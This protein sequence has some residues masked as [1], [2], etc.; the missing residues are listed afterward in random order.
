MRYRGYR[1][2]RFF[3]GLALAVLASAMA[4]T[5]VFAEEP[6][7]NLAFPEKFA[8]RLASYYI[9]NADTTI[10][11]LTDIGLGTAV[12]FKQD[13]GGEDRQTV[14]RIDLFYRINDRHRLEFSYF[15]YQRDGRK[16]LQIDIKWEPFEFSIG[17]TLVTEINYDLY[18]I[19][20]A[21]SFYRSP[22]VELS[23]STGLNF[24]QY[25]FKYQLAG[26]GSG[27]VKKVNAPLPM[28]GLSLGYAI[29]SNWS[30]HYL[31]ESFFI[32]LN[33]VN[34]GSLLN[35]E[36]SLQYR[37]LKHYQLGI[38]VTRTSLDVTAGSD[39][40]ILNVIDRHEAYMIYLG[41]HL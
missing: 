11:V 33:D 5:V 3:A 4:P 29:N 7:P 38:G 25:S 2:Q 9:E 19:G 16:L 6:D 26:G 22:K 37:F 36:L 39:D 41:F 24:T 31:A 14:P 17:E 18:R 27:D 32:E 34:D 21:W 8:F 1:L 20:Y 12:D 40:G 10:A 28:V 13:L 23:L 15:S 30:V 35:Y